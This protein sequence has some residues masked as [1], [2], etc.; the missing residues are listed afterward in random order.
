MFS[1]SYGGNSV[2]DGVHTE[3]DST[4]PEAYSTIETAKMEYARYN[5]HQVKDPKGSNSDHYEDNELPGHGVQHSDGQL[6]CIHPRG[7]LRGLLRHV[8]TFFIML[9]L[10]LAVASLV[11][12]VLLWF[13]VYDPSPS[14][15]SSS[16]S[17]SSTSSPPP[18]TPPTVTGDCPCPGE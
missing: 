2:K 3:F 9:A 6:H 1:T 5:A 15:S 7:C 10:L 18:T 8:A 11:L 14:S 13:A 4:V 12:S 16:S 17:L